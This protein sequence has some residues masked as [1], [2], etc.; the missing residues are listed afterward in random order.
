MTRGAWGSTAHAADLR[1][2]TTQFFFNLLVSAIDVID[3]VEDGFAIGD[4]SGDDEGGGSAQVA[5]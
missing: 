3:A 5:A 2:D 4:Q 1:S